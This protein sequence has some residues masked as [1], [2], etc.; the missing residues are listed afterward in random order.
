M[1]AHRYFIVICISG[2]FQFLLF[3]YKRMKAKQI[4]TQQRLASILAG[5][6][7]IV[8]TKSGSLHYSSN[9]PG[10]FLHVNGMVTFLVAMVICATIVLSSKFFKIVEDRYMQANQILSALSPDSHDLSKVLPP[11]QIQIACVG[12]LFFQ[13]RP[14]LKN[15]A[16]RWESSQSLS[17]SIYF[18]FKV[19]AYLRGKS[20]MNVNQMIA[21]WKRQHMVTNTMLLSVK[22]NSL[23]SD[24]KWK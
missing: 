9:C 18:N 10:N 11:M 12:F 21:L 7:S 16:L 13:W 8:R 15:H 20:Q 14:F 4:T 24:K 3:I 23:S 22:F 1:Q 6:S 5:K 17:M 2:I 19:K